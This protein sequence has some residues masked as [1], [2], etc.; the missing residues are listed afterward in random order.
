VPEIIQ[1][2]ENGILIKPYSPEQI[3]DAMVEL[4][5]NKKLAKELGENAYKTIKEKFT[6]ERET[7]EWIECYRRTN[8]GV[9]GRE[10]QNIGQLSVTIQP[11]NRCN[12][13]CLMCSS[14]QN[15]E[16]KRDM[17]LEEFKSIIDKNHNLIKQ[18][19]LYHSGESLLNKDIWEMVRYAKEKGIPHVKISTNGMLLDKQTINKAIESRLD[20]LIVSLDGATE[21]TY[22][23]F[24]RGGDFKR[25]ITNIKELVR[26]RNLEKSDLQ[27]QIQFVVFSHNEKEIQ[28]IIALSKE[29]GADYVKLKT[30]CIS[31][32]EWEYLLPTNKEYN[33]Y[34]QETKER[35]CNKIWKEITINLDGTITP[36]SYLPTKLVEKLKIGNVFNEDLL[37]ILQGKRYQNFINELR[38][39]KLGNSYCSK[40]KEKN[41]KVEIIKI[42]LTEKAKYEMSK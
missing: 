38:K 25:V 30:A 37:S 13:R 11:T 7:K 10:N 16:K 40:C 33:R 28:D 3:Y 8:Y 35:I 22:K 18:I 19:P 24:R 21:E 6:P 41:R 5:E 20:C 31:G 39:G 15:G 23:K 14:Y 1:N 42:P 26:Q 29:L 27:I 4:L 36:C 9:N 12:L 17:S 32:K 34:T 2:R